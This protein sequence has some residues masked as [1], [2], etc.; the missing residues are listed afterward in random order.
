MARHLRHYQDRGWR[1]D[2]TRSQ[3]MCTCCYSIG[4]DPMSMSL[5]FQ[6]KINDRLRQHRCPACGKPRGFC[7]C[8]SCLPDH[9]E[10]VKLV[11][12]HNNRKLRKALADIKARELAAQLWR[13]NIER[14]ADELGDEVAGDVSYALYRHERPELPWATVLRT[15]QRLGME[16]SVLYPAWA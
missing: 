7:T 4:C 6:R 5:A 11:Q 10:G 1:L 12:T 8:K 14:I 16:P 13:R 9:G 3:D 2:G 15:A